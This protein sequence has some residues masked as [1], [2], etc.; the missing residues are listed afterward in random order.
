M[1][2]IFA[3]RNNMSERIRIVLLKVDILN[4]ISGLQEIYFIRHLY[5]SQKQANPPA[6]CRFFKFYARIRPISQRGSL[7]E[8]TN[9]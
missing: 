8:H 2:I 9:T 3:Y 5:N 4:R 1:K 7:I 6:S